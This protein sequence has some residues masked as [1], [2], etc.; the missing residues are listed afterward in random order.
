M[1]WESRVIRCK[2]LHIEWIN[3]K[4]LCDSMGGH[5]QYPVVSHN[6]KEYEQKCV[7]VCIYIYTHTHI[8]E[9]LCCNTIL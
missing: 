1:D 2:L 8:T 7:C 4:G 5:I 3:N 9:S 6:G